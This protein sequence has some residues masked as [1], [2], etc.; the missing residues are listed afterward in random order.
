MK[1]LK[2]SSLLFFLFLITSC[3]KDDEPSGNELPEQTWE[4]QLDGT[5]FTIP[6]GLSAYYS[7]FN[8]DLTL[9]GTKSNSTEER[10]VLT[11]SVANGAPFVE[12]QTL[13]LSTGSGNSVLYFD[14]QDNDY[15][16]LFLEGSGTFEVE[17]YIETDT[18]DFLS[19][20]VNG[21]LYNNVDST[22]VTVTGFVGA[23][24][25]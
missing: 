12:G 5:D 25:F 13:D 23:A 7:S 19:G 15:S 17:Q 20:T 2:L 24:T 16:S 9:V 21:V 8:G 3:G 22:S 18:R 11:F 1:F 4:I 10:I 6:S 14:S